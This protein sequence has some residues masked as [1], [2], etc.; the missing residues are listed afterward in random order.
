MPFEVK[1]FSCKSSLYL[2]KQ[3]VKSY[4]IPLGKSS[5]ARFKDGEFEPAFGE[6]IR[7]EDVFIY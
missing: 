6:S 3:I 1:I 4:G 2:G 7:G 5:V